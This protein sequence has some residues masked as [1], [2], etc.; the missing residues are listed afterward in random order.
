MCTGGYPGRRHLWS[1]PATSARSQGRASTQLWI[2]MVPCGECPCNMYELLLLC[3]F[4]FF[5]LLSHVQCDNKQKKS[6]VPN[7][8][9][10]FTGYRYVPDNL[11]DRWYYIIYVEDTSNYLSDKVSE[12]SPVTYLYREKR[13]LNNVN[14]FEDSLGISQFDSDT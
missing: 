11:S 7:L 14:Q 13:G 6:K 8:R 10:R 4:D 3:C 5:C 9:Y 1:Q 2:W 12:I